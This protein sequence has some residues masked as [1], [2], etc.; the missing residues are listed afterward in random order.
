MQ[1]GIKTN[2]VSV[3]AMMKLE[4]FSRLYYSHGS[5]DCRKTHL[6]ARPILKFS[7]HLLLRLAGSFKH[8]RVVYTLQVKATSQREINLPKLSPST[9]SW[10]K[11]WKNVVFFFYQKLSVNE[12]MTPNYGR[13]SVKMFIHRKPIRF[14]YTIWAIYSNDGYPYTLKLYRSKEQDQTK[15]PLD[16]QVVNDMMAAIQ[17]CSAFTR[18]EF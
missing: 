17:F 2:P 12:F 13:H 8:W 6:S 14:L 10:T 11:T 5:T 7:L 1:G 4:F 3:S 15:L 18:N 9:W 16:T